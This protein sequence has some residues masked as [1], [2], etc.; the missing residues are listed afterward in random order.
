MRWTDGWT[1]ECQI[2]CELHGLPG[3]ERDVSGSIKKD[4]QYVIWM[5]GCA[6][7]SVRPTF[8]PSAVVVSY[9]RR[10]RTV[11]SR[12]SGVPVPEPVASLS[13][14]FHS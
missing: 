9:R 12:A 4:S 11:I 1:G 10:P 6:C 3:A 2:R 13:L 7:V 5:D 8:R 14:A